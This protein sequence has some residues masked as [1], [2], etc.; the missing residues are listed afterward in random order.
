[1]IH[2]SI[3]KP[4][5]DYSNKLQNKYAINVFAIIDQVTNSGFEYPDSKINGHSNEND[6]C[7]NITPYLS[8]LDINAY[9][10]DMK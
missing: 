6:W 9:N 2:R 4:F 7:K 10:L 5:W 8:T 1:M 3:Q